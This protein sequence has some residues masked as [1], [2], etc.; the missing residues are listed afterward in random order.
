MK[1]DI[2]QWAN[3]GLSGATRTANIDTT[4]LPQPV[5]IVGRLLGVKGKG[6]PALLQMVRLNIATA[7]IVLQREPEPDE[8]QGLA[9]AAFRSVQVAS[10]VCAA[11]LAA[12]AARGLFFKRDP[13]RYPR[14]FPI[15]GL[16]T[17]GAAPDVARVPF[18]A[19]VLL[20]GPAARSLHR[21]L[22]VGLH[23]INW[24]LGALPVAAVVAARSWDRTERA[25]PRLQAYNRATH[26]WN[27]AWR[28]NA[29]DP[30][31]LAKERAVQEAAADT[32]RQFEPLVQELTRARLAGRLSDELRDRLRR[33]AEPLQ[34]RVEAATEAYMSARRGMPVKLPS[35]PRP[36]DG[37]A[38]LPAQAGGDSAASGSPTAGDYTADGDFSAGG[39]AQPETD[40]YFG[41]ESET[42]SYPGKASAT[43]SYVGKESDSDSYFSEG[44]D[45]RSEAGQP[46][47]SSA[48]S[49]W[50]RLRQQGSQP[51]DV[52]TSGDARSRRK[53]GDDFS[54]SSSEQDKELARD[55]AQKDFDAKLDRERRGQDF[56]GG[57]SRRR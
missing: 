2:G 41:K 12:G 31:V 38:T 48:G 23:A 16:F 27:R 43:D 17:W 19:R 20:Q 25:D 40:S 46:G 13:Y 14:V 10:Q 7:E 4:N 44:S 15:P 18:T 36:T 3:P 21:G 26:E 37:A 49:S 51:K 6:N 29:R 5:P 30:E 32:R 9:H 57:E 50:A 45:S 8:V 42:D 34:A 1:A 22:I 53:E 28:A 35:H 47:R 55:E 54:F 33:E 39:A 24:F 11:G 56:Y 52:S